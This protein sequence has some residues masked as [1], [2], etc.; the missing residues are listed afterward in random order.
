MKTR[1]KPALSCA[2]PTMPRP[3]SNPKSVARSTRHKNLPEAP[4]PDICILESR[5]GTWFDIYA[6]LDLATILPFGLGYH[7]DSM[8]FVNAGMNMVLLAALS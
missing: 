6:T 8:S 3:P 4:V 5:W 1:R 2:N 7:T